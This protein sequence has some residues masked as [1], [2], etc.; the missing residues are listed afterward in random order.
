MVGRHE[1]TMQDGKITIHFTGY[2]KTRKKPIDITFCP[3]LITLVG[4]NG[5]GKSELL[6]EIKEQIYCSVYHNRYCLSL[7]T[8]K[9]TELISKNHCYRY[10]YN[11]GEMLTSSDGNRMR[12]IITDELDWINTCLEQYKDDPF[13]FLLCDDLDRGLSIDNVIYIQKKFKELCKEHPNLCIVN[14]TNTYEF[15]IG[16]RNILAYTGEDVKINSYNDF[17]RLQTVKRYRYKNTKSEE[18]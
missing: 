16:A 14:T 11:T 2:F 7:L 13:I 15:T 9:G 4:K 12:L 17:Y 1:I 6:S 5:S 18:K 3:G 8:C 10:L